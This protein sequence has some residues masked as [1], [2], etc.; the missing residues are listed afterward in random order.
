MCTMVHHGKHV[1]YFFLGSF[2]HYQLATLKKASSTVSEY[3]HKFTTLTDTLVTTD[4]S[5]NDFELVSFLLEVVGPEYDPFVTSVTICVNPIW[6][7]DLYSHL[8]AHKLRLSMVDSNVN[9]KYVSSHPSCSGRSQS[10]YGNHG[11][12]NT[13]NYRG[14]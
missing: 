11:S 14:T 3:F 6:L 8:L 1:Y 9:N 7:K 2:H 10:S 12:Y 4:Q 5:L 13:S